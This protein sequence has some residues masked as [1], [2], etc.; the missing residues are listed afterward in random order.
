MEPLLVFLFCVAGMVFFAA[1]N[2]ELMAATFAYLSVVVALWW[3]LTTVIL[4]L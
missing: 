2:K 1:F 3:V 4:G